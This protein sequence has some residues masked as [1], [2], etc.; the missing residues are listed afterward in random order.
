MVRYIFLSSLETQM[1]S[2]L[3]LAKVR[4][5]ERIS[6]KPYHRK[7]LLDVAFMFNLCAIDFNNYEK[8][9]KNT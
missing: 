8:R 9:N 2:Y 3:F 6:I 5:F 4:S 1:Y 7:E